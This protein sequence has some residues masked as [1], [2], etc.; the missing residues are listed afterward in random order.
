M[1][2]ILCSGTRG[3]VQPYVAL[4]VELGKLGI[5]AQIA[6]NRDFEGFVRGYG[7]RVHSI[8]VDFES[9]NVDRTM[10]KEA[11]KADNVLK[12]FLSFRKMEKYGVH[13]VGK[14]RL[15]A[16]MRSISTYGAT[17]RIST[18]IAASAT[19]AKRRAPMA[20][21]TPVAQL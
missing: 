7:V 1:V 11:Q 6:V 14:V 5:A 12:M 4:A 15:Y 21:M 8:D 2:T 18:T 17:M 3:D 9:L 10:V 16:S 20:P 19:A 13:M